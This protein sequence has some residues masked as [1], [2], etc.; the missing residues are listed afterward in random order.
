MIQSD[1][2][3]KNKTLIV[4]L[5]VTFICSCVLIYECLVTYGS[6]QTSM[7]KIEKDDAEV[8][9]INKMQNPNPVQQ[10]ADII[11]DNMDKLQV[12]TRKLLRS[13]G[14]PY[15]EQLLSFL[16]NMRSTLFLKKVQSGT[17]AKAEAEEPV[18]LDY[19]EDQVYDIFART[20]RE[21]YSN[22]ERGEGEKL[23]E[24]RL[25]IFDNFRK[26]LI[27]PSD[28]LEFDSEEAR[29]AYIVKTGKT[30]DKAMRRFQEDVKAVENM[31]LRNVAKEQARKEDDPERQRDE[32]DAKM[33]LM[34][35]LG[36]PRT[37]T[38]RDCRMMID[39]VELQIRLQLENNGYEVIPGLKTNAGA[40][41]EKT[42]LE[43]R[44][45]GLLYDHKGVN[46][47][48]D[49][50]VHILR[51]YRILN[52]LFEHMRAADIQK[53]DSISSPFSAKPSGDM[54]GDPVK[55]MSP[56][57]FKCFKY[58]VKVTSS[59]DQIRDFLDRLHMAYQKNRVYD[60][61]EIALSIAADEIKNAD[62]KRVSWAAALNSAIIKNQQLDAEEETGT[63]KSPKKKRMTADM[64]ETA[65]TAAAAVVKKPLSESDLN[66]I[67]S[68]P[69]YAQPVIGNTDQI[70]AT[71][72]F[73]YIVY[74]GNNPEKDN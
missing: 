25:A 29:A 43:A 58:E 1:F 50:V 17:D 32:Q 7:E 47:P 57:E 15:R 23:V 65:E 71:V 62:G 70:T 30:F 20:V 9:N 73:N 46:P 48:Q 53:V 24:Q 28:D 60:I 67:F 52:D 14:A 51:H 19:T 41:K 34:H 33:I 38:A 55:D 13:I 8:K 5:A 26:Q 4:V 40:T 42:S 16:N 31:A 36:L 66:L 27:E 74:V 2:I 3:K 72:K 35:A 63:K 56:D 12:E 45:R 37:M 61:T 18:T 59:T 39:R 69:D 22:A 49:N 6:I 11:K 21:Y 10:S 44:I 68:D 64:Q 54:A